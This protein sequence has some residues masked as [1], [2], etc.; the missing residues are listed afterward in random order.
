MSEYTIS[1]K[2][3]SYLFRSYISNKLES[4]QRKLIK[5]EEH[6]LCELLENM[7]K[8]FKN[9]AG[10]MGEPIARSNFKK[11]LRQHKL[12]LYEEYVNV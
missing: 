1:E 4:H 7:I 5:E 12:H 8:N 3:Y 6:N 11:F 2:E 10:L 9:K